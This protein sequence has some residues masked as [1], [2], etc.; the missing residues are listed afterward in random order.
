MSNPECK[1]M[2]Y[3]NGYVALHRASMSCN[4]TMVKRGKSP[5]IYDSAHLA[6]TAARVCAEIE[7]EDK[8]ISGC[9]LP[10]KPVSP[11][12]RVFYDKKANDFA[13]S[14]YLAKHRNQVTV[15]TRTGKVIKKIGFD[16][17]IGVK[18]ITLCVAPLK[19]TD[20]S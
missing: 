6:M 7:S 20:N 2:A 16:L 12:Q 8:T 15:E 10:V 5:D 19:K 13:V 3:K 9:P 11:E 17:K 18:K 14:Q 1:V 4:W